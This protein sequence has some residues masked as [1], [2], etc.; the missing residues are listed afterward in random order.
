MDPNSICRKTKRLA[1]KQA[2]LCQTEPEIVSEVVKG[3]KLGVRE[4]Q[5]QFR[6]RRWNC[7]SHNKYFGKVLQQAITSAGVTHTVTQ[8]CSM[9]E[10]L[11]C[12]CEATRSRAPPLPTAGPGTDGS[13]WEW[14]G[15]GDDVE[16]GYEKSKQFMDAKRKKGKSDIRTLI[17]LHNNE[18]GRLVVL[19]N[20]K[21]KCKCHGTSGSC[22]LKTCWQVTPEFRAVGSLLKDRFHIATLIKAHNRNT[23]QVEHVHPPH[24]RRANLNE[25]IY[26]EKSP[27]FCEREPESDSAGT[28]GRICNKTSP[29]MENC[30]SLCCG[31]GHNILQQTR[32]ERCNCKFHWC[33]YVVCEEC[34]ITEWVSVCK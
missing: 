2:E 17:D 21:R 7:T 13:K 10:L 32:S 27:D 34:R 18:A 19:D 20:M 26:F 33:C 4:C 16:F 5:F 30:E 22:Q 29:G 23:G 15:C 24:R 12:G 31:R 25:L 14:G 11:Q 3:A 28:Q 9:G 1:G 8:A 6:F